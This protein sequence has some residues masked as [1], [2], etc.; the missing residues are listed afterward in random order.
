VPDKRQKA[1]S[2]KIAGQDVGKHPCP[3]SLLLLV[4]KKIW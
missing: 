3:F 4:R 2:K 1:M